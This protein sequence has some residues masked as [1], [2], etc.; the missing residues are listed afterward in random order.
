LGGRDRPECAPHQPHTPCA[1][2]D[3]EIARLEKELAEVVAVYKNRQ[4]LMTTRTY[5]NILALLHPDRVQ[6]PELKRR[7]EEAFVLWKGL[8]NIIPFNLTYQ[9]RTG[10]P[11]ANMPPPMPKTTREM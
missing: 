5:K 10:V 1:E 8:E 2:K 6:E 3:R 11:K 4:G 9:E 7:Y